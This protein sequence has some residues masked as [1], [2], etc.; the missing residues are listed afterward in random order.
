MGKFDF[1]NS[2]DADGAA[3]GT[4]RLLLGRTALAI[5]H[6]HAPDMAVIL[7]MVRVGAP[8]FLTDM[9]ID[10]RVFPDVGGALY[11]A[12]ECCRGNATYAPNRDEKLA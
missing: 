10:R 4:I 3:R 8:D 12:C 11:G 7:E 1:R 5:A 6:H 2:F 9:R